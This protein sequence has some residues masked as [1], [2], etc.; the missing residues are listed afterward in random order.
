MPRSTAVAPSC[1]AKSTISPSNVATL[2]FP[3][4]AVDSVLEENA[5]RV[6]VQGFHD[7]KVGAI[8]GHA[9]VLN[10]RDT[11]LTRMQDVRYFVAFKVIKAAD[12]AT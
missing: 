10:V 9:D 4:A 1:R 8:C 2:T 5:M 3:I 6:L 7:P 11:W 12:R